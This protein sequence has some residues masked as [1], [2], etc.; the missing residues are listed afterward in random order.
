M[1]AISGY[2]GGGRSEPVEQV[3]RVLCRHFATRVSGRE[4]SA[5]SLFGCSLVRR[6]WTERLNAVPIA[7]KTESHVQLPGNIVIFLN[8]KNTFST[9]RGPEM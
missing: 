4:P 6:S 1:S 5:Q 7:S 3:G 2:A 9:E 8:L